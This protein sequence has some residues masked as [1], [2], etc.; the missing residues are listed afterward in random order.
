MSP[1]ST[2]RFRCPVC[3]AALRLRD[4]R[5]VGA[6]FPCPDCRSSLTL[7]TLEDGA[8]T[9]SV[10]EVPAKSPDSPSG[11]AAAC[12]RQTKALT[13]SASP[14]LIGWSVAILFGFVIIVLAWSSGRSSS[15][16]PKPETSGTHSPVETAAADVSP[17]VTAPA[18]KVVDDSTEPNEVQVAAPPPPAPTLMPD[19]D[20][21]PPVSALTA[22]ARPVTPAP[23]LP[24]PRAVLEQRLS[25]LEQ[26][27]PVPRRQWL[28]TLEDLLRRRIEWDDKT[29][30]GETTRL[31]EP[32]TVSLRDVTVAELVATLLEGTDLELVV[33][34]QGARLQHRG[35]APQAGF[36]SETIVV[37]R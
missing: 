28:L 12:R 19:P 29:L 6:V 34:D 10:A 26:R 16:T 9:I 11:D 24:P 22:V 2:A 30:Q 15:D 8:A 1:S 14:L 35:T 7:L 17:T 20:A 36:D 23:Q 18:P 21:E 5:F 32:V 37:P 3:G 25:V 13:A 4:R 27:R 31:D 33:H